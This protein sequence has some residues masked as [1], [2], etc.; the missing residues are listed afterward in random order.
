LN[1]VSEGHPD[2]IDYIKNGEIHL[3]INTS[4]GRRASMD[5][6][7]IRR[8]AIMYNIPYTTT[9]AGAVAM[10]DAIASLL[11]SGWDVCTLQDYYHSGSKKEGG[12]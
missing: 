7:Q 2:V 8:A 4:R 10:G 6:Y 9:I 11:S 1:K 12:R 3:M 5:G